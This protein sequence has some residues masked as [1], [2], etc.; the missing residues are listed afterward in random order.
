MSDFAKFCPKCYAF[1][2]DPDLYGKHVEGCSFAKKTAD[3]GR[4]TAAEKKTTDRKRQTPAEAKKDGQQQT[5]DSNKEDVENPLASAADCGLPS[6]VS[7]PP[8]KSPKFK[9]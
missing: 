8:V 3:S 7:S 6:A 4:Q 9:T 5:T 2:S 1:F